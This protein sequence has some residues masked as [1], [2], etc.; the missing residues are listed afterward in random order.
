MGCTLSLP[1][2]EIP[3]SIKSVPPDLAAKARQP[4]EPVPQAV[5]AAAAKEEKTASK[6]LSTNF[7][8]NLDDYGTYKFKGEIAAPYL[9]AQGLPADVLDDLLW[10]SKHSDKVAKAVVEWCKAK[11]ATMATCGPWHSRVNALAA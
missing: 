2:K 4:P 1:E 8:D 3:I 7:I 5:P 9:R 10:T 6:T 11:G